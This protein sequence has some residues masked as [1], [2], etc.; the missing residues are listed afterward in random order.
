MTSEAYEIKQGWTSTWSERHIAFAAGLGTFSLT[1]AVITSKG[2][3]VRFASLVTNAPLEVTP[4]KNNDPT[5][6]CL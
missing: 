1:R 2:C 4:R 6:N 3:N 5:A